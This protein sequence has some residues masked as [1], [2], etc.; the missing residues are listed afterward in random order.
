MVL[1]YVRSRK[2][3][4]DFARNRRQQEI[5]RA[6]M[7]KFLSMDA[8]T[9]APEFYEIY[10]DSVTTDLTFTEML[11]LLPITA[12]LTISSKLNQYYIGPKQVYDW[13]T[14]AG[15]MVLMP[16]P[17]QIRKVLRKSLISMKYR[18]RY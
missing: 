14:P 2:T 4:N 15:A 12:S 16:R 6:L 17:D 10:K 11:P 7:E 5:I 8:I 1:W 13:I 3:T 9:R 18:S